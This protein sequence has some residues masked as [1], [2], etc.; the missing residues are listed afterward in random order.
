MC[1]ALMVVLFS[2]CNVE[3][4]KEV[5]QALCCIYSFFSYSKTEKITS[6]SL[7]GDTLTDR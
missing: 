1:N 3:F 5:Y 2:F 7:G 6:L 4:L